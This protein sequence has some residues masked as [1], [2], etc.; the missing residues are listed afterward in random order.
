MKEK[1]TEVR[2]W[3]PNGPPL[4]YV[5]IPTPDP[6]RPYGREDCSECK[7]KCSGHYMKPSQQWEHVSRGGNVAE[8]TPPSDVIRM[9]YQQYKDIPPKDIVEH[10]AEKVLLP[11]EE[12][13]MWFEHVKT[14][15][16]NRVRGAKK[17]VKQEEQMPSKINRPA[18]TG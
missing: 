13:E 7:G 8:A 1:S 14:T 3:F 18:V 10:T 17:A 4:S 9:T 2:T 15:A 16:E 6:N 12:V 5:P 11:L